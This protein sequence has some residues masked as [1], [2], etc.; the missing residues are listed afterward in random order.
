MVQAFSLE[1]S[2]RTVVHTFLV[3][4]AGS[5]LVFDTRVGYKRGEF[6]STLAKERL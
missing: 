4:L 2:L 6:T 5:K 3:V 1:T